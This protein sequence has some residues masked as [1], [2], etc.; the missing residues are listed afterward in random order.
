MLFV[1]IIF[2]KFFTSSSQQDSQLSSKVNRKFKKVV[3]PAAVTVEGNH[4]NAL[5]LVLC[6]GR[7]VWYGFNTLSLCCMLI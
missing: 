5:R 3:Q 7:I 6:N 4:D 2:I 1:L